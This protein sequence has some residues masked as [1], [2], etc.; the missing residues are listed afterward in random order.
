VDDVQRQH[1]HEDP[2]ADPE[3]RGGHAVEFTVITSS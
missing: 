3:E 2:K 1:D